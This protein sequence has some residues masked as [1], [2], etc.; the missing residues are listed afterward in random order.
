MR[1]ETFK[2][3]RENQLVFRELENELALSTSCVDEYL[4]N[5]MSLTKR[6]QSFS[7]LP[8]RK[9]PFNRRNWGHS[10]HGL[11]SYQSRLRASIAY[12]LVLKF[13]R[14]KQKILDPFCGVGTIPFEACL[15]G[16]FGIGLDINPVAYNT[17]L[18]KTQFPNKE[19]VYKIL[20]RLEEHMQKPFSV[21]TVDDYTRRYYH[22]DTLKEILQAREFF[23]REGSTD[24]RNSAVSFLLACLLHIL[25]GNR[26]YAL[27]RRSHNLTPLAPRGP[28]IYKSVIA[29]LQNKINL[30]YKTALTSTYVKGDTQMGSVFEMPFEEN[31]VDVIL[32]S[33]PFWSS[34]RFYANNRIRLWFCGWDYHLQEKNGKTVFL[35]ELQRNDLSIYKEVFWEFARVLRTGGICVIHLG[36]AHGKD[37]GKFVIDF[38]EPTGLKYVDLVYE[39]TSKIER[40]GMSDQGVTK[41]QQFLILKKK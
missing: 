28:T 12:H 8:Y 23:L 31:S 3:D 32:T 13:S 25:H 22:A 7:E 35:E 6:I 37:I 29:K 5:D 24:G 14:P 36:V 26:P 18:A 38:C 11:C 15:N 17:T 21:P 1:P 40:H 34:T 39:N 19:D 4:D 33:P 27:S 16:R 2:P 30:S 9:P 20:S 10:L 41:L